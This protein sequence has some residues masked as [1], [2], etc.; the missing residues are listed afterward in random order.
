MKIVNMMLLLLCLNSGMITANSVDDVQIGMDIS[1]FLKDKSEMYEV[2]EETIS[3]EGYESTIFNV[4][5]DSTLVYAVEP[6]ESE[7]GK[8]QV[9]RI[10]LYSDKFKTELEL[11]VG[12]TLGDLREKYTVEE[13]LTGEGNVAV[14][15]KEIAVSFLLDTSQIP[16]EWWYNMDLAELADAILIDLIII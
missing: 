3:Q 4:Y 12:N 13:I 14:R 7:A 6:Q 9:W 10:W 16:K 2:K 11:G 15:V 5:E 1:K 8:N